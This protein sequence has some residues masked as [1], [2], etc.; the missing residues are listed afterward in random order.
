ML[1][2][3]AAKGAIGLGK[4]TVTG[5]KVGA[6][7]LGKGATE[8]GK[9]GWNRAQQGAKAGQPSST[10]GLVKAFGSLLTP[11]VE[12]SQVLTEPNMQY[13]PGPEGTVIGGQGEVIPGYGMQSPQSDIPSTYRNMAIQPQIKRLTQQA[14]QPDIGAIRGF[15]NAFTGQPQ[16]KGLQDVSQGR[17][18]AYYAGGLIPNII[19]SKLGQPSAAEATSK[20]AI[21]QYYQ[22]GAPLYDPAT[23]QL[24]GVNIPPRGVPQKKETPSEQKYS[25]ELD[26]NAS[27]KDWAGGIVDDETAY[28]MMSENFPE[29]QKQID[30]YYF[31]KTGIY[32]IG[33]GR[34]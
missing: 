2:T 21:N 14:G 23:G 25:K 4:A 5:A 24:T 15:I 10:N 7:A 34:R 33:K 16:P 30:E 27:L 8:V 32:P 28:K 1:G 29:M 9:W 18:T 26:F 22:T 11:S 6:K 17:K 12:A 3:A 31:R 19:M 13:V 20:Q